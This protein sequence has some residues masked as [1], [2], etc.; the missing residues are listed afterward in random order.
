MQELKTKFLIDI[1]KVD[2]YKE[3]PIFLPSENN[4]EEF[5]KKPISSKADDWCY[6]KEY[7]YYL[8]E[9]ADIPIHLPPNIIE[10][11]YLGCKMPLDNRHK[12]L[13]ILATKPYRIKLFQA[14]IEKDTFGLQ[15]TEVKF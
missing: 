11:V 4:T 12:I 3:Y 10:S 5:F 7:R 6:E 13:R 9:K 2:Y 8:F 1:I 15:F 14:S